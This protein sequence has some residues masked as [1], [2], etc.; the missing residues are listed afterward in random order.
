LLPNKLNNNRSS[1]TDVPDRCSNKDS[2][3]A[4]GAHVALAW[5]IPNT[6]SKRQHVLFRYTESLPQVSLAQRNSQLAAGARLKV[7]LFKASQKLGGFSSILGEADV[8]LRLLRACKRAR[9]PYSKG[10]SVPTVRG[11][12]DCEVGVGKGGIGKTKAEFKGGGDVVSL[13]VSVVD[14]ELLREVDLDS[15]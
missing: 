11:S 7:N 5:N 13:H 14:E 2:K 4:T 1:K 10:S 9:V 3:G 8:Q 6:E 12:R 15:R